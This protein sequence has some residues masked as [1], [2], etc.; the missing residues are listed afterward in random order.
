MTPDRYLVFAPQKRDAMAA[1]LGR[2]EYSYGFVLEYFRPVLARMGVVQELTS[3]EQEVP[4]VPGVRDVRLLFQPPHQIPLEVADRSIPVFAWEYTTI[5]TEP[6]GGDPR[7]DWR[8]VLRRAPGAITHSEFAARAVRDSVGADYPVSVMPAPV[9]DQFAP[10]AEVTGAAGLTVN[11]AVLDSRTTGLTDGPE[12][13]MPT[14]K[15]ERQR[16]DLPG[17]VYT[18]V[19]N[20]YDGRKVWADTITA[21]AWA[22]RDRPDATLVIKLVHHDRDLAMA[23]AWDY[24]RRLAPY[25][26]R[27]VAVHGYLDEAEFADLVRS[28]TYVVNSSRGEGQ[29][30]PLMEFMSA[31][32][33]AVAPDHTA[34]ADY[35]HEEDAFVVG[36]WAEW[37]WWPHD[38]RR[39]LR[40]MRHPV[41]WESLRA[42][43]VASHRVATEE[44]D[45]YR[46]MSSAASQTL[47]GHCSRAVTETRM[48]AFLSDP[49]VASHWPTSP[50][51]PHA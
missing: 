33:P 32:V 17:V 42:A 24:M 31:G 6:F 4:A 41:D 25:R 47:A 16:I 12:L 29:C 3:P 37:S 46:T 27:I 28:T 40:C 15:V 48:K 14:V 22:M 36:S 5:P 23:A 11:A 51:D 45:R 21:F 44:P 26:C 8:E 34:M 7:N 2:S 19:V 49:A 50:A 35:V 30:L 9:W 1:E 18:T 20:P 13:P 39:F 38:P 43:F 10:L